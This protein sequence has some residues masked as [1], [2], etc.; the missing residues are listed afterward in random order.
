MAEHLNQ[1]AAQPEVDFFAMMGRP[2]ST[3]V[4]QDAYDVCRNSF[5]LSSS[6]AQACVNGMAE[7]LERDK[8]YHAQGAAMK[9][10]D[11]TGTYRLMAML[12]AGVYQEEQ[13]KRN[14]KA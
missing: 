10:I 3:M 12:L 4:R 13:E 14:E 8:P 2:I 9:Y 1:P 5:G 11:L 6:D 7:Q